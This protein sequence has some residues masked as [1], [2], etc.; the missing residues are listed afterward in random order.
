MIER[1][2]TLFESAFVVRVRDEIHR[3]RQ[4]PRLLA[5]A[6][7][8]LIALAQP[9]FG[10]LPGLLGYALLLFAIEQDFGKK[11]NR[12]VF[13]AGWLAGFFYFLIS[14]FW[15]AS[16][17]LVDAE[18]YGWMAPFAASLLPAGIGLFW[19]AFA[20]IY[21]RFRPPFAYRY[22]FFA[23]LFCLFEFTRGTILSGFPWNP[24]GATWKAGE[25]MS[26]MAAYVGVYGLSLI[27]LIIFSSA[28][29][30]NVRQGVKGWW[31][32]L[33]GAGLWLTCFTVGEVRLATTPIRYTNVVVRVVQPDVG[34]RAKWTLGAFDGI[35]NDY[36]AMTKA[37]ARPGGG[38]VHWPAKTPRGLAKAPPQPDLIAPD[39]VIW[40][41]GALPASANDL[42]AE[43]SWTA[44]V[45][46][47][48]L[49][50][51]QSLIVGVTRQEPRQSG[52]MLWR[53]SMLVLH[54]VK[55]KTVIEGAYDKHKLVPFGEFTPVAPVLNALGFSALTHFDDSFT[56]GDRTRSVEFASV[57]RFLPLICYEGIFPSL[58]LTSY[59]SDNDPRR[60]H[61]IVNISNDA[62]F[63]P[64]TGPRQHLN[65]ASY[66]AIEEGLPMVRSTPTGISVQVDPLGRVINYNKLSIGERG[67]M[68]LTIVGR[69]NKTPYTSLR[70]LPMIVGVIFCLII[71]A[72]HRFVRV[73]KK[74][75]VSVS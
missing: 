25:A 47:T 35:F 73:I 66:R 56:P 68:D 16:A 65:L 38:V 42:F 10:F 40:P 46:A 4:R 15:V 6:S 2:R 52:R 54:K 32:V 71:L 27:T 72:F 37:P 53:N 43:D 21:R 31:P 34:Q 63:G 51:S 75:R 19:G 12:D 26:Q 9:P 28:A 39:I 45:L 8:A 22:L 41:E 14:C 59:S 57:P 36:V 60:P 49:R 5:A 23:S 29:V 69:V 11:P 58:D 70:F 61:W 50:E 20:V 44:P 74:N 3:L 13:L 18:T 1:I 17:F 7:G 62:W 55:G 30:V 64:T 67:Y 48:M 24:A 33:L